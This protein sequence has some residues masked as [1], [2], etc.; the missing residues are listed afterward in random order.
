MWKHAQGVTIDLL[1]NGD[2]SWES[3]VANGGC[4]FFDEVAQVGRDGITHPL[5]GKHLRV[6][7]RFVFDGAGRNSLLGLVSNAA[8]FCNP[9][10]TMSQA[11][12]RDMRLFGPR[13]RTLEQ[14][15]KSV[16]ADDASAD[17]LRRIGRSWHVRGRDRAPS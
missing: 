7:H 13:T 9:Y 4:E 16:P 11:Q 6:E 5:T 14:M 15:D 8:K 1:Y 3:F 12:S 17:A 2:D 10:N